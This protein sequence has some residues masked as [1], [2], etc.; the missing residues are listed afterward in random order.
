[1]NAF[2]FVFGLVVTLVVVGAVGTIWW[3]AIGDGQRND[4]ARQERADERE[5]LR[6]VA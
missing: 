2:V 3:A 6:R 1:V 4:E 5:R